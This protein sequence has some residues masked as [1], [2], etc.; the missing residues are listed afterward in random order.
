MRYYRPRS[1]RDVRFAEADEQAKKMRDRIA[2]ELITAEE[3]AKTARNYL[4][5]CKDSIAKGNYGK[6]KQQVASAKK[7]IKIV[8]INIGCS[9]PTVMQQCDELSRMLDDLQ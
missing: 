4:K 6:A 9:N 8:C 5:D 2:G 7:Y 3:Y 1:Y